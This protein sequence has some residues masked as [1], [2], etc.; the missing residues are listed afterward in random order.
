[1]RPPSSL[2]IGGAEDRLVED[3]PRL[4][5]NVA[6]QLQNAEL[7]IFPESRVAVHRDEGVGYWGC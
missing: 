4:A 1:M 7:L 6:E 3:Y 2:V 5:R